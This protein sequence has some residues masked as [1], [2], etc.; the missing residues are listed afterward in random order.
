MKILTIIVLS[1]NVGIFCAKNTHDMSKGPARNRE[2]WHQ[3]RRSGAG[4]ED[5]NY[6]YVPNVSVSGDQHMRIKNRAPPPKY[7]LD[8]YQKYAFSGGRN[9]YVRSILPCNGKAY[10]LHNYE[11]YQD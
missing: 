4:S 2:E 3:A 1:S 11:Y 7:M 8:L 6:E 9:G 5:T 10:Y